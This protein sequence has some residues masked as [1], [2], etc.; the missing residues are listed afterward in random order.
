M[1]TV[2]HH[3]RISVE[4]YFRLDQD[5][6]VRYEYLDGYPIL[7]AGGTL[8]HST[9]CLN[10]ASMLRSALRGTVCRVYTSDVRVQLAETRFVYP[11]VTVSC[12]QEMGQATVLKHP[13]LVVE[14]LSPATERYDRGKKFDYYRDCSSVQEYMLI[15]VAYQQVEVYRREKQTLWSFE[16]FHPGQEVELVRLGCRFSV[17]EVYEG[18]TS[19]EETEGE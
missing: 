3:Q 11:D 16:A 17:D 18:V 5:A 19:P 7:L 6:E 10:I 12:E 8:D 1:S 4:E 9:V 15:N 14:V 2:P 13:R